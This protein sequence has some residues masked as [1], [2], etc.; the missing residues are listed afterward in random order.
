MRARRQAAL[1]L[2]V[3]LSACGSSEGPGTA[4]DAG[5]RDA[6][7]V[8]SGAAADSSI[9]GTF[10]DA[11][12]T[13]D[14]GAPVAAHT[15]IDG[16]GRLTLTIDL[17]R[18]VADCMAL[19]T[20]PAP[21]DD[22]DADQLVDAWEDLALARLRPHITLDEAEM[23]VSDGSAVTA[24]VGRVAPAPSPSPNVRV[25]IMLGYSRDYGSCGLTAHDGDSE[26]V[27]LDLEPTGPSSVRVAGAY[28]AA[29][30][31]TP[32]DHGR[33]FAG[34]DL[35]MLEHVDD[36]ASGEPRWRVYASSNKHATYATVA[37]CEGVSPFP[38]FDEDCA[39]DAA[40]MPE[41]FELDMVVHNAGEESAPRLTDLG[42]VGFTGDHAW[43]DQR[44]CG[45]G[46]RDGSCSS[47]VREKLLNDPF[48]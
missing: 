39:P 4:T 48:L 35:A 29:H 25:F 3:A 31:G 12:G 14:A 21:C 20:P 22:A 28:T 8:D 16:E 13:L 33:R 43:L 41:R 46:P 30:E 17:P 1:S 32:T 47:P 23:L 38:C 27:A 34:A 19:A 7:A 10:S 37:I 36:P 5:S 9:D 40:E 6:G 18:G 42:P 24:M 26:R 11:S 2:L 44:F 15:A 45:G